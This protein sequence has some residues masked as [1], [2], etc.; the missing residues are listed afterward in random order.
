VDRV[1]VVGRPRD[2]AQRDAERE[3]D[4]EE[5]AAAGEARCAEDLGH[6]AFLTS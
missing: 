4:Q 2:D 6:Q 3:A 1:E 5:D